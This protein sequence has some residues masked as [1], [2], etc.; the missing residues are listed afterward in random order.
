MDVVILLLNFMIC[1][2]T[3]QV[4]CFNIFK[5]IIAQ[6]KMKHTETF[7]IEPIYKDTKNHLY[8]EF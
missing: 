4:D 2:Y 8:K 6:Y 5:N 3:L 7:S 1:F